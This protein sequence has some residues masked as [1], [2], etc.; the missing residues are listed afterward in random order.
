[1]V[2]K[3][4]KVKIH[5]IIRN[6]PREKPRK[7]PDGQAK[8]KKKNLTARTAGQPVLLFPSRTIL[9]GAWGRVKMKEC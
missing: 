8:N 3:F 5:A 1:M 6:E 9:E 7:L 2:Y 4:M